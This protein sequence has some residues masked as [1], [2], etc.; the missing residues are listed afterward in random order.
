MLEAIGRLPFGTYTN[1]MRVDGHEREIDLRASLT[2]SESDRCRFRG[3]IARIRSRYQ[4]PFNLHASV[5]I[6]W[7]SGAS[8]EQTFPIMPALAPV[9]VTAPEGSILNAPP[10]CGVCATTC[11]SQMLPDVV[12]GCL[13]QVDGVDVPAEGSSSLWNPLLMNGPPSDTTATIGSRRSLRSTYFIQAGPGLV[14]AKMV[15]PPQLFLRACVTPPVEIS[16]TI[17]PLV[18]WR[19]EYR[20]DSGGAGT[21]R[22]GLGQIMEVEHAEQARFCCF[23][24][25]RSRVKSR[26][27]S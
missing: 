22:G 24:H 5:R 15:F 2:I 25:V 19:K 6:V 18:V 16:E 11:H 8:S 26:A 7:R 12:L 23:G 20:T 9:R 17:A 27:R 10:P 21:H 14:R 13:H 3:Y 1:E 4:R